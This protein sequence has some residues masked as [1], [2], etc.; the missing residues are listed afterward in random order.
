MRLSTASLMIVLLSMCSNS[1]AAE[2]EQIA[3][4]GDWDFTYTGSSTDTIPA[5]PPASSYDAKIQVPARWDDQLDRFKRTKWWPHAVFRTALGPVQYL[6][7]IGWHRKS[8]EVPKPW[9]GRTVVLT[10]GNA[11]GTTN[12]W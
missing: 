6:S 7:G 5:L 2:H 4:N 11:V 12:V 8:I 3:L 9:T 10:V 1:A